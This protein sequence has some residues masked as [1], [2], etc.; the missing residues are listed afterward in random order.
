MR[1]RD[2]LPTIG[3]WL[4]L[5]IVSLGV[6]GPLSGFGRLSD[7]FFQAET[8]FPNLRTLSSWA[9]YK[10]ILWLV[11]AGT[12][13][14]T[15]SAG[16]RL[17]KIHTPDSVSF[18]IKVLWAVPLLT[19]LTDLIAGSILLR[20]LTAMDVLLASSGLTVASFIVSAIWTLYLLKSRRVRAVYG[21][22]NHDPEIPAWPTVNLQSSSILNPSSWRPSKELKLY[23]Y[24][25]C[26]WCATVLCYHI[27]FEADT[28]FGL[29]G[30]DDDEILAILLQMLMPPLLAGGARLAYIRFIR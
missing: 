11:Y 23:I 8:N 26:V 27:L 30:P 6:L 24:W 16:Y 5:L 7:A 9:H 3:G 17:W 22:P 19:L 21:L 18:A 25:S 29:Y 15:V 14:A 1:S 28:L 4:M 13:G 12:A 10:Q 2:S 20:G